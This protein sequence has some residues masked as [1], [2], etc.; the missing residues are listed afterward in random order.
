VERTS[1]TLATISSDHVELAINNRDL[2]PTT[3]E[4]ETQ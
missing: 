3:L 1:Q 2:N 4:G